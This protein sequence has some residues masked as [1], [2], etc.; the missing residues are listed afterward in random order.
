MKPALMPQPRSI[1]QGEG[2]VPV[3]GAFRVEWMG[4]HSAMLDR[5]LSRFQHGVAR[6]TGFAVGRAGTARLRIDCRSDKGDYLTI[7]ASERYSLAI[8][9]DTVVLMADEPAGVLHGL[10][11]LRQSITNVSGGFAVPAMAI[12]DAPRFAWR[13]VMIDVARH[14]MSLPTLERQIDAMELVKLN[15]LH[16]HL[17]DTERFRVESRLY[18]KLHEASSTDIYSQADIH[19]LVS[20][21]ADRGVRIVPEFDVTGHSLAILGSALDP[22]TFVFLDRL[23][24]E[25]AGL[26]PDPY[27][28]LG[29]DEI[30]GADWK[31]N[32]Q[33]QE[34][35]R[36]SGLQSLAELESSFFHRVRQGVATHGKK[37]VGWEEVARTPVPDDVVVQTWRSSGAV[38]RVTGQGNRVIATCG[39]Y[40]DKLWP[41][42]SHYSVDP[43][44][45][46]SSGLTREQFEEAKAKGL[47]EGLVAEDEVID[48]SLKLSAAQRAL[49]LGGEG[50]LW[51]EL[52][53]EEMLDGRLWPAA[54]AVA[55][56]LWSPASVRDPRD[57]YRRLIVVQDGLRVAGLEDDANRRRMAE[58]LAPGES[59]PVALLLDLVSPVRN[60]AH[61]RGALALLN[62]QAPA[63]Q[64]LNELADAASADSLVARHFALDAQR[65]A[66]GDRSGAA[67]L[68]ATLVSW[69]DNH[70][71][72]AKVARGVP[73][74]EAALPISADIAALAEIGLD[75]L[76]GFVSG[77]AAEVL[78]R[79]AAA[80]KASESIV[81]VVTTPQPAA[82]LL[83]SI[84]PGI[85]T[86]VE[87][88]ATVGGHTERRFHERRAARV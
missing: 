78:D 58:R 87:V 43:H 53:T 41:C 55:E 30:S 49:V 7:E 3:T 85:R 21:A 51:T 1:R 39:Y 84:T 2:W 14:F 61:N 31:A 37:V 57:M 4:H 77:H 79:Q 65:F 76:A 26:F 22:D 23:F 69:R 29:G 73:Q 28:H 17:S 16:L 81:Q 18:P 11:T 13:G 64:D 8:R 32:P 5:A 68:E 46:T 52:V 72:F 54:A 88:A 71:R 15:V 35:M 33:I 59:E 42:E 9:D 56:R 19:R 38:A 62:G 34:F 50:V 80:A 82:D 6:R 20:Y 70:G 10:A 24:G 48:P 40:F 44:D 47:P 74:L 60:H 67:A 63:A 12:D 66:E 25:M 27:F 36:A 83:I 75:A 45:P 86:L